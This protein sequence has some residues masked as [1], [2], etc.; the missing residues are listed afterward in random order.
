MQGWILI[1]LD[2]YYDWR[3]N[4]FE[5]ANLSLKCRILYSGAVVCANGT[6]DWNSHLKLLER[7]KNIPRPA[8]QEIQ[9]SIN[10]LPFLIDQE[11]FCQQHPIF[12]LLKLACVWASCPL[13]IM[14]GTIVY[15]CCCTCVTKCPVP[16]SACHVRLFF[17]SARW[18]QLDYDSAYSHTIFCKLWGLR[19]QAQWEDLSSSSRSWC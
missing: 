7:S 12:D 3:T 6:S 14:E 10:P 11:V 15:G 16:L 9:K 4:V 8:L 19:G 1:I 2:T 5:K 17:L 13:R 18:L